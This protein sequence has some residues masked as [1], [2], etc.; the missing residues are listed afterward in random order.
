MMVLVDTTVWIDF[1]SGREPPHVAALE[2]LI[3]NLSLIH[4]SEPT[5]PLYIS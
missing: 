2:R 5:R 4:I 1:F 3:A